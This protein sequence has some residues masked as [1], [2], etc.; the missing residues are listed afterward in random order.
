MTVEGLT[1]ASSVKP[2]ERCRPAASGTVTS[3]LLPLNRNALPC[4]PAAAQFAFT[5]VPVWPL[6]D[7]SVTVVPDPSSNPYA[8]TSPGV[9]AIE[10][11]TGTSPAKPI[12]AAAANAP[13][14]RP[15][16]VA[17][18]ARNPTHFPTSALIAAVPF[19]GA[20][21]LTNTTLR[22]HQAV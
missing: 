8:A 15:V 16:T 21:S 13:Q 14:M 17:R 10:A 22:K 11:G 20:W 5:I 19:R 4:L 1:H 12:T 9:A 2:V 18:S 6:P 7:A 3:A